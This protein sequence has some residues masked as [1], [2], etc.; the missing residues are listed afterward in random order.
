MG[1]G[2]GTVGRRRGALLALVVA[3]ALVAA[4]CGGDEKNESPGAGSQQATGSTLKD[5]VTDGT[6][7]VGTELPA[8]PFWIGNDYDSLSGGFEVDLSKEIAKRVNLGSVKFIEMPFTGLVAGQRCR[9]DIDFSQVTIT[10]DRARVVEFTEPYFEADQGVLVKKGTAVGSVDDAKKL[11]W[12]AQANTTGASYLA[13]TLKPAS[14]AK[15]YEKTVDMF[16]AFN[17]RQIN[18]VLLDTPILLGAVKNNQV[19]DAEVVGQFKTGEQYGGV[20]K[21]DSP[22]VEAF[23]QVIKDLKSD[24]FISRL[25]SKYFGGDPTNVPVISA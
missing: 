18:A 6:L 24:G 23:N 19:R 9:C 8:P 21:K 12:G 4:G 5:L 20:L 25:Y 22:N 1:T 16:T 7:T 14:E 10:D 17:A 15:L 11:R 2:R 13:D 3:V